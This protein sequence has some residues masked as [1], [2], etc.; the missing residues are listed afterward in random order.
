MINDTQLSEFEQHLVDPMNLVHCSSARLL[1]LP[2]LELHALVLFLLLF[3]AFPF[4]LLVHLAIF[5]L[6]RSRSQGRAGAF[7]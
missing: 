4:L 3:L 1:E 6:V 2:W 5:F 7:E